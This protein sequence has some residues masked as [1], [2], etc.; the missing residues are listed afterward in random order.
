MFIP[1][2]STLFHVS[3]FESYS[4]RNN[5]CGHLNV[6]CLGDV[7]DSKNIPELK[8]NTKKQASKHFILK[9]RN[10]YNIKAILFSG[11]LYSFKHF[12]RNYDRLFNKP[13]YVL[14]TNF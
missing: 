9:I 4:N 10:K 12:V 2:P 14:L 7:F 5:H 3:F 1:S 6:L 8:K 11:L 13:N